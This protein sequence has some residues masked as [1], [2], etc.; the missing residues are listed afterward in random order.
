MNQK[1]LKSKQPSLK[2]ISLSL[3]NLNDCMELDEL[4]LRGLWSKKQWE[5]EL[6]DSKRICLGV[7]DLTNLIALGCGW[8]V[9]DELHLTAMAVHP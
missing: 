6:S 3:K 5:K 9:L 8:V 1:H 4:V 2:V 7:F